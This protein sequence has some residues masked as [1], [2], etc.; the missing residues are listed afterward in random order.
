MNFIFFH[1]L[2][3]KYVL[4]HTSNLNLASSGSQCTFTHQGQQDEQRGSNI[5]IALLCKS[6][7]RCIKTQTRSGQQ[8]TVQSLYTGGTV[9]ENCKQDTNGANKY[10]MKC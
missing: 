3:V 10:C 6:K 7:N 5:N 9:S 4:K 1:N 2:L 8:H